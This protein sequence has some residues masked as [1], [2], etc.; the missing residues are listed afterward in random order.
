M[1]FITCSTSR[2]LRRTHGICH[3]LPPFAIRI[4]N[5]ILIQ[6]FKMSGRV[7]CDNAAFFRKGIV[8]NK[9]NRLRKCNLCQLPIVIESILS[10][11]LNAVRDTDAC[12]ST[13]NETIRRYLSDGRWNS[14]FFYS[15][16]VETIRAQSGELCR[17]N[18]IFQIRKIIKDTS[19]D[20]RYA[21]R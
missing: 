4:S 8:A 16:C 9:L 15:C 3:L 12:K 17:Q 19:A 18:Y 20:C 10:Y 6:S 13:V 7:H 1:F 14:K 5:L 2:F 11:I 21:I